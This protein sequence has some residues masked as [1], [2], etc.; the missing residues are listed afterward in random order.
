[1]FSGGELLE[2]ATVKDYLTVQKEGG[3]DVKRKVSFYNL[4]VIISV[5]YRVKSKQGTQFRIWAGRVLKDYLLKGYS[6]NNRMNRIEDKV[7]ALREKVQEIDLQI[8]SKQIP[9][10]LENY[11]FQL[12]NFQIK[13]G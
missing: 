3:R 10:F 9:N 1:M 7:E 8:K 13:K 6:I 12:L 4:D 5:G 11:Q 2:S